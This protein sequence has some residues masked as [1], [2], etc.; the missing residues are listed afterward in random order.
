MTPDTFFSADAYQN[1]QKNKATPMMTAKPLTSTTGLVRVSKPARSGKYL[2]LRQRS[3][4]GD[5]E[6]QGCNERER[7][8]HLQ[9]KVNLVTP[10]AGGRPGSELESSVSRRPD[11]Q[12]GHPSGAAGAR[13]SRNPMRNAAT[14]PGQM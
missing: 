8:Q 4:Q 13:G 1:R 5:Q 6:H 11:Q 7:Q 3:S 14:T 9:Q 2:G 10:G 12:G